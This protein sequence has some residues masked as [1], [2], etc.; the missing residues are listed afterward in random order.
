MRIHDHVRKSQKKGSPNQY[1]GG[2][3]GIAIRLQTSNE[4]F[5]STDGTQSTW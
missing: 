1:V 5:K 4:V 2:E 3:S